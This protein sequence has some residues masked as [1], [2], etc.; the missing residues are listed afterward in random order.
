MQTFIKTQAALIAGSMADFLLT[1]LLVDVFNSW[2]VSSNAAGNIIG[3][4]AQFLLSKYWVFTEARQKPP[5]QIYKFIVMW[6]GNIL[7]SALGVYLLTNYT[8]LHYLL[9]KLLVSVL[10][11]ISYTY[12]LSK[13]FVFT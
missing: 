12:L 2:Y 13:K 6:A 11:G 7:L 9:S 1:W 10:L 5:S 3:A 8:H 4:V